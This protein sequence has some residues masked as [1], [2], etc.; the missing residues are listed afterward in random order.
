MVSNG[1]PVWSSGGPKASAKVSDPEANVLD[2]DSLKFEDVKP[3]S[4]SRKN[5]KNDKNTPFNGDV[6]R[7]R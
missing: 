1:E 3:K 7:P 2:L 6:L 4:K 5:A